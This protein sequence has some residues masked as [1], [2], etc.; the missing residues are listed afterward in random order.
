MT[1]APWGMFEKLF[2]RGPQDSGQ[3]RKGRQ[4]SV[5]AL[6]LEP[7]DEPESVFVLLFQSGH[8]DRV[9]PVGIRQER[10]R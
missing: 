1:F 6:Q 8:R 4:H 7:V 3:Q 2:N 9:N 10:G 5:A